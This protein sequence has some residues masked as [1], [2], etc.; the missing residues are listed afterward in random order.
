MGR[1]RGRRD[2][3]RKSETERGIERK[4]ERESGIE[5]K[6]RMLKRSKEYRI[7]SIFT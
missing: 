2:R 4:K 7:C 6:G 1:E 3:G 5:K